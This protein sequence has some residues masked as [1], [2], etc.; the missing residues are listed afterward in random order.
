MGKLSVCVQ[1]LQVYVI[2]NITLHDNLSYVLS[3]AIKAITNSARDSENAFK[4]IGHQV[5]CNQPSGGT[6]ELV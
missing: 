1:I 3:V 2:I 5:A 6:K 4:C